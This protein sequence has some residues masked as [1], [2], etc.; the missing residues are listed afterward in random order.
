M[1]T[2]TQRLARVLLASGETPSP[3]TAATFN[4]KA[5]LHQDLYTKAWKQAMESLSSTPLPKTVGELFTYEVVDG[6]YSSPVMVIREAPILVKIKDLLNVTTEA[7][8]SWGVPTEFVEGVVVTK[9]NR[10]KAL[11]SIR[12]RPQP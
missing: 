12:T 4:P 1:E 6:L 10:A 11:L 2:R 5:V 7:L 3:R 8:I 9:N